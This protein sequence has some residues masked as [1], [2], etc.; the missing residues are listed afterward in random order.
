MP[1]ISP[2]VSLFCLLVSECGY[3]NLMGFCLYLHRTWIVPNLVVHWIHGTNQRPINIRRSTN[4]DPTKVRPTLNAISNKE[5]GNAKYF[6]NLT[7]LNT[8]ALVF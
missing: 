8:N 6:L 3:R 5:N 4:A 1:I 7:Q 2:K